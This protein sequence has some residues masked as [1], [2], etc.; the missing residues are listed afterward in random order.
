MILVIGVLFDLIDLI[1]LCEIDFLMIF[2]RP[3]ESP[4]DTC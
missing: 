2:S 3:D 4:T 1:N